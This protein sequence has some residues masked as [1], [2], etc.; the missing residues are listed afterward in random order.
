MEHLRAMT[1]NRDQVQALTGDADRWLDPLNAALAQ[2]EITTPDRAAM[3]LA[4]CA[5]ES[6]GFRH[7]VENLNYTAAQLLRTWPNRFTEDDA[8]AMALQ[9]ERIAERAY[10]GRMGN[11]AEGGGDGWRFRGRGII[12]LTGRENYRLAGQALGI[13]AT[14]DPDLLADPATAAQAAGWFWRTNGCNALA[15]A[16]DYEGV[17]RRINGG[18]NGWEDRVRWLTKVRAV[19][20]APV[21]PA[22]PVEERNTPAAPSA[23]ATTKEEPMGAGLAIALVQSLISGFAPLAQQ[24]INQ[25]LTK[26]GVESTVGTQIVGNIL[27]AVQ[28]GLAQADAPTQIAAVAAAQKDAAVI[29][30]A[31]ASALDYLNAIAPILDKV[32]IYDR[33]ARADTMADMNNSVVRKT[34]GMVTPRVVAWM[35]FA[36]IGV[37]AITAIAVAVLLFVQISHDS[38]GRVDAYLASLATMV[39]IAVVSI[40]QAP[41]RAIFGA[42]FTSGAADAG[43]DSIA[44]TQQGTQQ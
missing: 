25:A 30:K 40:A 22:V 18:L 20:A 32:A 4:Q 15:D 5:H 42:W 41:F 31:E 2:W 44:R 12:Q 7:L 39:V 34:P 26:N 14:G 10:G 3:F 38:Q 13:D 33:E 11:A 16:G 8:A 29:A 35:T 17:T 6:G 21:A 1:L 9:P 27:N 19:L 24:K 43:R 37:L 23:L 36:G 28:P